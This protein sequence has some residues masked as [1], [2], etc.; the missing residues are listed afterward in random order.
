[1]LLTIS[2]TVIAA[3]MVVVLIALIPVLFQARR[4]AREGEKILETVRAQ[5]VP[6]SHDLT[7][8]SH[9]VKGILRSIRRQVD[10]V[11]EGID[12]VR[13]TAVRLR[14]FEEEILS[15]IEGP[16]LELATLVRA[17]SRGI[18]TFFDILRR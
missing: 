1:M 5:I 4:T 3:I 8:I 6:L 12:I 18:E 13:G 2:V 9:E 15:R 17:V 11:E 10:T 16:L 14:E 7:I